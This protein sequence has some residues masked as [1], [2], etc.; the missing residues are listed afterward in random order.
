MNS[1]QKAKYYKKKYA[2]LKNILSTT[3]IN[4]AITYNPCNMLQLKSVIQIP[5]QY[6]DQYDDNEYKYAKNSLISNI[7]KDI[8]PYI[9][10]EKLNSIYYSNLDTYIARLEILER[11]C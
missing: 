7:Q 4:P 5:K 3:K 10:I 9:Q 11:R 8:V 6:N 1:R 2:E